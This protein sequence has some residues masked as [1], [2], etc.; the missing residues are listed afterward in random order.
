VLGRKTPEEVFIGKKPEIGHFKI[1]G[2][3]VYCHVLSKKRMK[4]EATIEKGIFVGYSE[5]SKAY[6]FYIPAL[7]KTV[8]RRYVKFK[9]D[10]TLKKA[11]GIV[12]ITIGDQK[13]ETQKEEET[14]VT[15][16]GTSTDA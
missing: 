5:T 6:R 11:H 9:E 16:E 10:R 12:P 15:G 2:C 7:R 3:L 4:L 8:V 13:L 14:Q 1:F